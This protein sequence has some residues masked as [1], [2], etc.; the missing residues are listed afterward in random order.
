MSGLS[1]SPSENH[2]VPCSSLL[3][4]TYMTDNGFL[5]SFSGHIHSC[6]E[7]KPGSPSRHRPVE[8]ERTLLVVMEADWCRICDNVFEH[9]FDRF[10]VS[11]ALAWSQDLK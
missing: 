4:F 1:M 10:S 3:I 7:A 11:S 9:S 2:S 5:E 8:S 6:T